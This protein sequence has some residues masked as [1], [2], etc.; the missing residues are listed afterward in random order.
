MQ[1]MRSQELGS[2]S[3]LP[4]VSVMMLICVFLNVMKQFNVVIRSKAF[5]HQAL[6]TLT[7]AFLYN[8][9]STVTSKEVVVRAK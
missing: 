6:E 7:S 8:E 5:R 1:S 2:C 4:S 3:F 9:E